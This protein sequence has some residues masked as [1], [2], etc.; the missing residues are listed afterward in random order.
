MN[1]FLGMPRREDLPI[2]FDAGQRQTLFLS[3]SPTD[4]RLLF[5]PSRRDLFEL[6]NGRT[7]RKVRQD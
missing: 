3:E 2:E 5:V 1:A 7:D 4:E 6:Q